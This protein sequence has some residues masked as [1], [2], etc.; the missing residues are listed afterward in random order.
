MLGFRVGGTLIGRG[1][2]CGAG[3]FV[4]ACSAGAPTTGTVTQSATQT[5]TTTTTTTL[6]AKRLQYIVRVPPVTATTTRVTLDG[7][8]LGVVIRGERMI[9]DAMGNPIDVGDEGNRLLAVYPVDKGAGEGFF[10]VG[11]EGLFHS[12]TFRGKLTQLHS[13]SVSSVSSGP[14]FGVAVLGDGRV[15][16]FDFAGKPKTGLPVG[17]IVA[18]TADDGTMALITHGGRAFV[19]RDA[20]ATFTDVTADVGLPIELTV[21][22]GSLYIED[23]TGEAL[24]VD[25]GSSTKT[26]APARPV[27]PATKELKPELARTLAVERGALVADDRAM[28]VD[29]GSTYDVSLRTGEILS[30]ERGILPPGANCL[31]L[32]MAD[33]VVVL[34]TG[35]TSSVFKRSRRSSALSLEHS[36]AFRGVFRHGRGDAL[37][38]EGPCKGGTGAVPGVACLR[39]RAGDWMQLD[40]STEL[41]DP[42]RNDPL[43]PVAWVPKEDGAF[44]IVG[45]KGGGIWDA[46]TGAKTRLDDDEVAALESTFHHVGGGPVNH[47]IGVIEGGVIVGY[48]RDSVAFRISEGGKTIEKS[49]FRFSTVAFEGMRALAADT[50]GSIWQSNDW[51]W[52]YAEFAAPPVAIN[53]REDPRACS[54]VGCSLNSWLRIGWES[55]APT[56]RTAAPPTPVH[57]SERKPV[58]PMLKCT[59]TGAVARKA[60]ALT[61]D[62]RP[63]FGAE[64]IAFSEDGYLGLYPRGI[65]QFS[66]ENANL[67]GVVTG[68]VPPMDGMLPTAN[69]LKNPRKLRYVEPFDPKATL[70]ESTFKISDLLDAARSTGSQPPDFGMPEERGQSLLVLG[71]TIS[72]LLLAAPAPAIWGRGKEK[73]LLFGLP[74]DI[75]GPILSAVATGPDEVAIAYSNWEGDETVKLLGKGRINEAFTMP[76]LPSPIS[77]PTNPDVLAL[78]PDNKLAMVRFVMENPPTADDPALLL[79]PNEPPTPLAPWSKLDVDGSPA[80]ANMVGHRMVFATVVKWIDVGAAT[81]SM[82]GA[83]SYYLV[84][85]NATQLCLE[86]AEIPFGL[87]ELPNGVQGES[88]I[89]AKFGKDTAAGHVMLAEGGELREPRTCE[90]SK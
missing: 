12:K 6:P 78:S 68:K 9:V 74:E 51:G 7:G 23:V 10:F 85:W 88:Y 20:A 77:Q 42:S 73:P 33:G 63:G 43:H 48:G 67:R 80:C 36:F 41:S 76:R 22:E 66:S 25:G 81:T 32:S 5:A 47:K 71:N 75:S 39:T 24:R 45:G 19:S 37:L 49:P 38:F 70:S 65:S 57:V 55:A 28:V 60:A 21:S 62:G 2:L 35:D 64:N 1:L 4:T 61:D 89:V 13:G 83:P 29:N 79:R 86:A 90:L 11:S 31:P 34:C 44:L 58:L 15:R 53:V 54:E 3:L 87:H 56:E 26:V 27:P 18:R 72:V 46:R 16:A 69:A 82:Y 84:R 8:K 30:T 59:A 40:R 17:T 14:G 50:S 52:T